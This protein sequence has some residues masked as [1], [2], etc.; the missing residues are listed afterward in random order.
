[1][2]KRWSW[3]ADAKLDFHDAPGAS[4]FNL[5]DERSG[6]FKRISVDSPRECSQGVWRQCSDE[7]NWRWK[8]IF[9]HRCHW[10]LNLSVKCCTTLAE[11]RLDLGPCLLFRIFE[12]VFLCISTLCRPA[13]IILEIQTSLHF[14]LESPRAASLK[15]REIQ[16][17]Y[18]YRHFFNCFFNRRVD[19]CVKTN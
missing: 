5:L 10:S 14:I 17:A 11:L 18:M 9:D 3:K 19:N 8:F 4:C 15:V 13:C 2:G 16:F 6:R 7:E 1:M 12:S